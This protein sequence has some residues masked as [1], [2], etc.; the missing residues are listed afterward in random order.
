[1]VN[2]VNKW[3]GFPDIITGG[4]IMAIWKVGGREA[5]S[6]FCSMILQHFISPFH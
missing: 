2:L 3:W 6:F 5:R 1:M 4:F